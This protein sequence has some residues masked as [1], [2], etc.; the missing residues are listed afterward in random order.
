M[1]KILHLV[2]LVSVLVSCS[3]RKQV[4]KALNS[5]NYDQAIYDAIDKLR[6][7]KEAKR[8][9]DLIVLLKDAFNKSVERDLDKISDLKKTNNPEYLKSIYQTYIALDNRQERIKPLLPLRYKGKT[10]KFQFNDYSNNILNARDV[11]SDYNYE[12]AIQF[13]E[14]DDKYRIREAYDLLDYIEAIHPNYERTRELMDEA[15]ERGTANVLVSIVNNTQQVIPAGL[16]DALLD[17]DTYGLNQFWTRY[18]AIQSNERVY[19]YGM[20]LQLKTIVISPEQILEKEQLREKE[21]K[22]GWEY[23]LDE[24]GNVAKDSLGN[25]IKIDKYINVR[26]RLFEVQQLKTSQIIADVIYLDLPEQNI[27]ERFTIDSGFIFE[28]FYATFRG[29]RRA[30]NRDD[31]NLAEGGPVPFPPNEQMIYDCGEDLK[32]KL[33]KIIKSYSIVP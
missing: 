11:V 9:Q 17:F 16:E 25:D 14:T 20:Q 5:G 30:L 4:E 26:A 21:I 29:D 23:Q 3:T 6:N 22:D 19:D 8:K 33:K 15:H 24:N 13:L 10:V 7:N 18:D 1:K 32:L 28:N 31:I 27:L 2:L 12:K